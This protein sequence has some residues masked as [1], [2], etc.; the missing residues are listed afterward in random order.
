VGATG[1]AIAG[2]ALGSNLETT[3]GRASYVTSCALWSGLVVG[4]LAA[5]ATPDTPYS[6]DP[7]MPILSQR[8]DSRATNAFLAAGLGVGAG[9]V[10]GL[11]SAGSVAPSIAR[12][13]FLD[14][15]AIGG[16]LVVGGLYLAG[17]DKSAS[18]QG[19]FATVGLGAAAGLGVAWAATAGME[20]DVV[21]PRGR[22]D[23][24]ALQALEPA[25]IPTPGA[26]GMMLGVRGGL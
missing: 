4:S 15:G 26:R 16:V 5:A 25:L 14:L 10:A 9:T 1:G 17:S 3:P 6:Y 8:S 7:T 19:G 2:G 13:R 11:L 20:R 22:A 21:E 18:T 23:P 24:P 12:V